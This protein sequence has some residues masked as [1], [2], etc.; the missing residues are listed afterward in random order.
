MLNIGIAT[1]AQLDSAVVR[2]E[3][4]QG[5]LRYS[6][7]D[8]ISSQVATKSH[9]IK[10]VFARGETSAWIAPPGGL[11][12]ALM[13]S[14]AFSIAKGYEWFGFKN[15][16][17]CPVV[18]VAYERADLVK[19][20]LLAHM[21]RDGGEAPPIAIM[22]D[23]PNLLDSRNVPLFVKTIRH[24]GD[25][26]GAPIGFLQFDTF[27]KMIAAGGGDEDKAKDQ[28]R[29]FSNIQHIKTELDCHVALIGHT[30]KDES[31]GSRGS[32]AI[33]GDV[34]MLVQISGGDIKTAIVTKAN[35]A[36]E[37]RLF[38]FRSD[39][40][41]FGQDEDGDP[42]TV[43]IAVLADEAAAVTDQRARSLSSGVRLF[44]DC[45]AEAAINGATA[46]VVS[47]DGPTVRAVTLDDA[48][49][50]HRRKY[51]NAGGG[52]RNTAER[53]AWKKNFERAR[54]YGLIG[55]EHSNGR[56]LLWVT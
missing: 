8:E 13:A 55:A 53:Q 36:P 40:H 35:D 56:E 7:A 29:V 24:I 38:S 23:R 49:A 34:D 22:T 41:E 50:I 26:L 15:K 39:I 16:C 52:D 54:S 14:A 48:R 44:I 46:H 33:L 28:G 32:N 19:R 6:T 51:V 2:R 37:G 43:N 18:I 45:V 42:I 47:G 10:G 9:L 21:Q 30:G 31:R 17:A 11:K 25:E 5:L 12:S 27:A 3:A 1:N 4:R 20:R